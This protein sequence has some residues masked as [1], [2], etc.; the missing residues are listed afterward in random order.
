MKRGFLKIAAVWLA[1]VILAIIVFGC[2]ENYGRLMSS[3]EVTLA[4]K[5]YEVQ[6]GYTYYFYGWAAEPDAIIG[7]RN[8]YTIT[9]DLWEKIDFSKTSMRAMV[10]RLGRNNSTGRTGSVIKDPAGNEIGF[11]FSTTGTATIKFSGEKQI[12]FITPQVIQKSNRLGIE[13]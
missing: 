12:A 11:W 8:D 6:D 9:S 7:L 1:T 4:F 10:E 3:S 13:R 2:M 5:K